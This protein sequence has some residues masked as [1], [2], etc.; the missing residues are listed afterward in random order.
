MQTIDAGQELPI[1][2]QV[3]IDGQR[4][5]ASRDSNARI[6][7]LPPESP[8]VSWPE[9]KTLRAEAAAISGALRSY[10]FGRIANR[11][12]RACGRRTHLWHRLRAKPIKKLGRPGAFF[13]GSSIQCEPY[14]GRLYTCFV[15]HRD[16]ADLIWLI[17]DTDTTP[18]Y[19]DMQRQAAKIPRVANDDS[20]G[21][22][23]LQLRQRTGWLPEILTVPGTAGRSTGVQIWSPR[24]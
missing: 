3:M 4:W 2:G 20:L 7:Y 16:A 15:D 14:R 24:R 17:V 23:I 22:V 11:Y 5:L 19:V 6:G 18:E 10:W 13:K 1:V 21:T 9:W 12:Y 8:F